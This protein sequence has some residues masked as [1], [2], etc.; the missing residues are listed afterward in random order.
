[1]TRY[2]RRRML[3]R[4]SR[5]MTRRERRTLGIV[6][7]VVL[8]FG[9][10]SAAAHGSSSSPTAAGAP[11]GTAGQIIAFAQARE[12]CPYVWGGTGP[13]QSGYD[14]SGLAMEAYQAAGISIERTSQAQWA[15][16]QQVST[17]AP[18][19]LVFFAG[20]D[21]TPTDPGHVGIV[22]DPAQN[23]MIDAYATGYPVQ[24]Q[25]YGLSSSW[26]GLQTVVGFTDPMEDS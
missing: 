19:D 10:A 4:L 15:S 8:V 26:D 21:G 1:V 23:L 14:C 9:M 25:T 2:S 7:A 24:E 5:R 12:G 17:P 20:A 18:G 6:S 3:R 22:V 16:E 11:S 13:C